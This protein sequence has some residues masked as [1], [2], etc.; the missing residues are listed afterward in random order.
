M[1]LSQHDVD[2]DGTNHSSTETR[3]MNSLL[4]TLWLVLSH[5][6]LSPLPALSIHFLHASLTILTQPLEKHNH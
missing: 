1:P 4:R 6:F 2:F 5:V 3:A